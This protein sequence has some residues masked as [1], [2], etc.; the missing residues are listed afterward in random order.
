MVDPLDIADLCWR[1]DPAQFDF[2]TTRDLTELDEIIGQKRVVSAIRFAADMDYPGYN[3]FA[4]G[5]PGLGKHSTADRFLRER[6]GKRPV[7]D[8]WC[9]VS[10]FD[11]SHRPGR[12]ALPAGRGSVLQHDMA[13]FVEDCRLGLTNAFESEE[14]RTRRQVL[15]EEMN[16]RNE[17]AIAEVERDAKTRNIALVRTQMGFGLAPTQDGEIVKPDVFRAYPEEQRKEIEAKIEAI[18]EKLRTALS[19]APT[20][21][22]ETRDK[23]RRLNEDT[24]RFAV[25]GLVDAMK[26]KFAGLPDVVAYLAAAGADIIANAEAFLQTGQPTP[27]PPPGFNG[28]ETL[29]RRYRVNLLVDNAAH[30][31]APVVYEDNPTYDRL[32]GTIEYRAEMGAL[33]TDFTLIRPGAV[34][35]ANGGY[36]IVDARK[37]LTYPL[38]WEGLKQALRNQEI[39]IEPMARALGLMSTQTLEPEPIPLDV[40]VVLVG[41]PLLYYLLSEYDPE[42][43][44]LFKVMADFDERIDRSPESQSQ[45]ARLIAGVVNRESLQPFDRTAVARAMEQSS[46]FADHRGKFS[47]N[48][49]ALANL[50]READYEARKAGREIVVADDVDSAIDAA[51]FRSDRIRERMHEQIIEQTILIE[52]TGAKVGQINGLAVLGL[53]GFSFGKPSRITARVTLGRGDVVDIEREVKLGGPLHSKGVLILGGFLGSR[54]VDDLPLSLHASL[55]FEQSYG[56]V[57]GDSASSAELY[58]LLSAIAEVPLGQNFAVTGSVNQLGEVQAIGGVNEKIEGFFDICAAR[59][60]TG[61]Q[62]VLIPH[63]NIAHL[64]LHR[65]VC[66]A[67]AAGKFHIYPIATID[68]GIARLTG[69]PAGERQADGSF[70][71]GSVNRRVAD[72][73][74]GFA[75]RR[76]ELGKAAGA[77]NGNGDGDGGGKET[78]A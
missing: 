5:A 30:T 69:M 78:S 18:Q 71:E 41:E 27:P 4:L 1:C 28:H 62:G 64:M 19:H 17:E 76:I 72:R 59:G 53:G 68:E 57:D 74:R 39:R 43:P 73:L 66:D 60:L 67:V 35:R 25:T 38:S 49:S 34:H 33:T 2:E 31:H 54:Y 22:K 48:I 8:D 36:L 50:L 65:R 26:Q 70:P 13:T 51:T 12:L 7:P 21:F 42:F 6:A 24:A 47:A 75:Q 10:T 63:A 14:Y 32:L 52:T 29:F 44:N 61:D 23:I 16:E 77:G 45:Y 3:I 46:R 40:K 9:Y 15:E 20:W 11:D 55:V 56:G 37:L 58:C